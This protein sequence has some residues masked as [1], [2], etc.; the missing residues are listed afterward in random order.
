MEG[1][2]NIL[3]KRRSLELIRYNKNIKDRININVNDY[4][5]SSKIYSSIEMELIPVK[6]KF[7]KI[8]SI[9]KEDEKYYHIYFNNNSE[10]IKR[11]YFTKKDK[12]KKIKI[13]IDYQVKSFKYLFYFNQIIESI[14]F[15]KFFRNNITDMSDIFLECSSLKKV[16]FSN[17]N[18]D[19]ANSLSGMFSK[20]SG[21]KEINL[22]NFN[23]SNVTCMCYM[24]SDCSSL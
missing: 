19:N 14:Y 6:K 3:H 2:F 8:I 7:G 9:S 13:K 11:N 10:E 5:E 20:C 17:F 21:L 4:K 12:V 24:F 23:T 15:K 16:D 22:K 18:S 1:L